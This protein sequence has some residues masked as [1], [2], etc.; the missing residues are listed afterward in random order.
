MG[1]GLAAA[2]EDVEL[3][4]AKEYIENMAKRRLKV[5]EV[6]INELPDQ[7]LVRREIY[8]WN[9]HE[10]NRFAQ[11]T[12]DFLNGQLEQ[13]AP[14]VEVRVTELPTLVEAAGSSV[15]GSGTLPTNKQLG[16]FAKVDIQPGDPILNEFSLL[17]ANN[18]LM[19]HLLP[20]GLFRFPFNTTLL[21]HC[22]F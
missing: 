8:P 13:T 16:L 6:D 15:D 9:N 5:D 22:T 17:A 10:P 1:R 12:L 7:G 4:Q 14:N 3:L 18:R 21:A 20:S 11:E 19:L 2:P